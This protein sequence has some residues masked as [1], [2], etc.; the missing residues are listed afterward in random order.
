MTSQQDV[1]LVELNHQLSTA[2]GRLSRRLRAEKA[3]GQLGDTQGSVLSWLVKDGPH[4]LR[5]LSDREH[6][7]PPSMNQTVNALAQLGYL[8]REQDPTDGRKVLLVAT[9]AGIAVVRETRKRWHDW[10]ASQV[11]ELTPAERR[12]M[13][14]ASRILQQIA[15][16]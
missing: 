10:L 14:D 6:V 16:T 1:D 9:E 5:E 7:T 3:K 13:L 12:T 4:T 11:A 8:V 15:D 2:I